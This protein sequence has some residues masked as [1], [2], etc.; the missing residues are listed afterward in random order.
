M[1]KNFKFF[2]IFDPWDDSIQMIK[3]ILYIWRSFLLVIVFQFVIL[4]DQSAQFLNN[5]DYLTVSEGL[6]QNTVNDIYKDTRGFIW[7]G[8]NDGL[9]RF[10]GYAFTKYQFRFDDSTSLSNN[11]VYEICE[12]DEGNLWIGTKGGLNRYN[13]ASDN[14]TRFM[15]SHLVN[16]PLTNNFIRA[17]LYDSAGNLWIGTLGGGLHV[18]Y[19]GSDRITW[20]NPSTT[21]PDKNKLHDLFVSDISED[22]E[23]NIWVASRSQGISRLDQDKIRY[24]FFPLQ[25]DEGQES[26]SLLGKTMLHDSD[27]MIW[28]CTEGDGLYKLDLQHESILHF[29]E[30]DNSGMINSNIVKDIIEDRNHRMWIATDGGGLTI[31]DKKTGKTNAVQLNPDV[32]GGINS[33][34][35]YSL[36]QDDQYIVWIGTFAGG[37]NVFDPKKTKFKNFTYQSSKIN[38]LSHPSVLCFAEDADGGVW[39]G[40]DGGGLNHFNPETE[41]FDQICSGQDEPGCISSNVITALLRD[42]QERLWVGTYN[43]GLNILSKENKIIAKYT[44]RANDPGGLRNNNVWSVYQDHVGTVWVGTSDGLHRYKEKSETFEYIEPP[45][46]QGIPFQGRISVIYEDDDHNL[47]F[48]GGHIYTLNESGD[49]LRIALLP[50]HVIERIQDFEIRALFQD[51]QKRLWIGTEGGG[52]IMYD[53]IHDSTRFFSEIDGLPNNSVH[54]IIQDENQQLWLSTNNGISMLIPSI[55]EFRNYDVHDGLQSN[56]FSYS[57]AMKTSSGNIYFGGVNGFNYF[58]PDSI[59]PNSFI[60]PI[61]ITNFLIFNRKVPIGSKNS[62]LKTHISETDQITLKHSQSVITFEFTA[63]N[64]TSSERNQYEVILEG[65]ENEWRSIGTQRSATFTNLDAGNYTFKVRGSNNDLIW[66]DVGTQIDIRVLP[67][68]WKS[69]Y[70]YL[71]Y[72]LIIFTILIG[73]QRAFLKQARLRHKLQIKEIENANIEEMNQMEIRFFTNISHEFKTPLT[74]I[75]GPLEQIMAENKFDEKTSKKLRVMRSNTRRLMRLINQLMEFRK[76]KQSTLDLRVSE[77]NIYVFLSQ[78][79]DVFSVLAEKKSIDFSF[80][81]EHQQKNIWFDADKIEKIVYNL[82]S[83]AFKHTPENGF[84][85]LRLSERNNIETVIAVMNSGKG[86]PPD[87]IDRLFERFYMLEEQDSISDSVDPGSGIGLSLSKTLI[88]RHYGEIQVSSIPGEETTFSVSFPGIR[89]AYKDSEI[90]PAVTEFDL[91]FTTGRATDEL[92][93]KRTLEKSD[94]TAINS[95]TEVSNEAVRILLVE[96]NHE[97]REFIHDILPGTY[98][99]HDAEDGLQGYEMIKQIEPDLIISDVMMPGMNGFELCRLVKGEEESCHIPLI[100]LTAK[101]AEEDKIE[102]LETGAD[103]YITKPFNP[104]EFKQK[105]INILSTRKKAWERFRKGLILEPSDI[106][107]TSFDEKFLKNAVEAVEQHIDDPDFDVSQL[108]SK[109]GMS[110][111]VMYRKLK[112]LTGQSANEFIN[113]LRLKR[114]AQLLSKQKLSISEITYMVG[115]NDPQYFSK[116]FKKQFGKTPSQYASAGA[117]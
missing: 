39:I 46:I 43:G 84:I 56:Q 45:F 61:V 98:S 103:D 70:A 15:N 71:I 117:D 99:I 7:I 55:G 44:Y 26:F 100:L 66:N 90:A 81:S 28:V 1:C 31:L 83:N 91:S 92:F 108:V 30:K 101:T 11:R 75:K 68:W 22:A 2:S 116:C 97:V 54:R 102:G 85:E 6:S 52:L 8:T 58:H 79:K 76:I 67:P 112:A 62:P 29:Q 115:Y 35:I 10:D 38:S 24:E 51:Q 27:G 105:V 41:Y 48:G 17:L 104:I 88:E 19:H 109:T 93:S 20:L 4:A 12:D 78:I 86:I 80:H 33:N 57:G 37:V 89:S 42:N 34:A 63:L 32:P 95:A 18:L 64:Y 13:R 113:T 111:S 94:S 82:L 40:T 5:F 3:R 16:S 77:A 74:L 59:Q 87:K 73:Y 72:A 36:L 96:D 53:E 49:K 107:V 69:W 21:G 65:F 14:F 60:P 50:T 47:W 110:R 23:G 9:N 106:A 114:A 25:E